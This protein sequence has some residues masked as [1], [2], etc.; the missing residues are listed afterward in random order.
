MNQ[1][2][3]KLDSF[4]RHKLDEDIPVFK[5]DYWDKMT[6]LL[7]NEDDKK[8]GTPWFKRGLILLAITG[9]LSLGTYIYSKIDGDSNKTIKNEQNTT[10][11]SSQTANTETQQNEPSSYENSNTNAQIEA[12]QNEAVSK[13]DTQHSQSSVNNPDEASKN[14]TLG[15]N[16][17]ESK[18]KRPSQSSAHIESNKT[19]KTNKKNPESAINTNNNDIA[20]NNIVNQNPIEDKK[21]R[22]KVS[23]KKA[24]DR[25]NNDNTNTTDNQIV[26]NNNSSSTSSKNDVSSTTES[27]T[28]T[29]I[30]NGTVMTQT[31]KETIIPDYTTNPSKYNPRYVPGLDRYQTERVDSI[32]LITYEP[33]KQKEP[34]TEPS[35]PNNEIQSVTVIDKNWALNFLLGV[36]GNFGMNGTTNRKTAL[37]ISPL[38]GI[39]F[40]YQLSMSLW[41]HSN[42]GFS[43][44]NALNTH[45]TS[46]NIRYSFGID[47]SGTKVEHKQLF[48]IHLP[49]GIKYEVMN[50]HF[51]LANIGAVMTLDASSLV[52]E[53]NTTSNQMG[54]RSGFNLFDFMF[55]VGY[56]YS[57]NQRFALYGWYQR[58]F[59]DMTKDTYFGNASNDIQQRVNIGIKYN[60]TSK[61]Q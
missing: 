32:V 52:R 27:K 25:N 3:N 46:S 56:E 54:Y 20:N 42:I 44:F 5:E 19:D 23:N 21:E 40:D 37:G 24:T 57:L 50:K 17:I 31:R 36:N 35:K 48:Q 59:I 47:S 15:S 6:E 39:G 53:N 38:V 61:R 26:T 60:F 18:E 33:A 4:L 34:S 10:E 22:K 45:K 43:Y 2:D 30:Y 51:V 14:N 11:S 41:L 8:K 49:V 13:I 28:E 1:N 12:E 9:L 29:T 58:G 7:D 55:Q 16:A